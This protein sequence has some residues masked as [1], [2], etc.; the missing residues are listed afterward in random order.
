M[1]IIKGGICAPK[2][3]L[4]SATEANIKYKNRTDMAMIFSK[5]PILQI[6]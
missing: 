5:V 2:G 6:L 3:F 4:A 1:K